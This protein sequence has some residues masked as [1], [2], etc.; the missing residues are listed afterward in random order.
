MKNPLV[1]G[2]AKPTPLVKGKPEKPMKVMK[3]AL[4]QKNLE[5]LGK[6]TLTEKVQKASEHAE[7]P[8]A[9]AANLKDMLDKQEHSRVWSKYQ[10]ALKGKSKR[11]KGVPKQVQGREGHG[12]CL[13]PGEKYCSQIFPLS[14]VSGPHQNP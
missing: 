13:E 3:A 1:K 2:K 12:S 4:K 5:K 7:T 11:T 14:R 8:Q 6:M 10:T 9:A